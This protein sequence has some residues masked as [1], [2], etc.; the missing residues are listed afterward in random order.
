MTDFIKKYLL[1]IIAYLLLSSMDVCAQTY[2]SPYIGISNNKIENYNV[3]ALNFP[4]FKNE[5]EYSHLFGLSIEHGVL[6][7]LN[8]VLDVQFERLEIEAGSGGYI[9]LT[10][11]PLFN[12]FG[13]G[14]LKSFIHRRYGG[15]FGLQYEVLRSLVLS[16]KHKLTNTSLIIWHEREFEN[17]AY[18]DVQ[19]LE[20]AH[21]FSLSYRLN[22]IYIEAFY[23]HGYKGDTGAYAS[24]EPLKSYGLK[25]GYRFKILDKIE[26]K[27]SKKIDCPKL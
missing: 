3:S 25:I 9:R 1:S 2:L 7:R 26:N 22:K 24:V 14:G 5:R 4:E 13:Q 12:Y 10:D 23:N 6:K 16:Y 15:A 11:G 20:F 17:D 18:F 19:L 21:Q 8:L 27:R